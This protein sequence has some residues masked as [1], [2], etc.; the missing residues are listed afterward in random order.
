MASLAICSRSS[1]GMAPDKATSGGS[2]L[3]ELGRDAGRRV[4]APLVIMTGRAETGG[5][6]GIALD[7]VGDIVVGDEI[8]GSCVVGHPR[9]WA[10]RTKSAATAIARAGSVVVSRSRVGTSSCGQS[11]G[12][13]ADTARWAASA[14]A[15]RRGSA[16]SRSCCRRRASSAST[17][18]RMITTWAPDSR[19]VSPGRQSRSWKAD[20]ATVVTSARDQGRDQ[21]EEDVEHPE[22]QR[23]VT[24]LGD[25]S[26]GSLDHAFLDLVPTDR[27]AADLLREPVRE[28]CLARAGRAADGDQGRSA[29]PPNPSSRV[30]P[31]RCRRRCRWDSRASAAT[32]A[33]QAAQDVHDP[34]ARLA[35]AG[36][37]HAAENRAE[38]VL[39]ATAARPRP[40]DPAEG[41]PASAW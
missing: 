19:G 25:R 6:L 8:D 1:V 28:R 37:G 4:V 24:V 14:W 5:D 34:A 29:H 15:A 31:A 11:N 3:V 21:R 10:V 2:Q 32:A 16:T 12:G 17:R 13:G 7:A 26:P 38:D 36:A 40:T 18:Q 20:S 9:P 22:V 33:E 30:G 35:T 39:Q 23:V 41:R 27:R